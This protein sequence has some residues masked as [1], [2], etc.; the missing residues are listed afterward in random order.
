MKEEGLIDHIC[1]SLHAIPEDIQKIIKTKAFEGIT[2]SYSMLSAANMLPVLDAAYE[3]D[4]G[5]AVMNP[6][7][8]GVIA[9]N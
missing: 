8:G 1:C 5:V 7:G 9:Q 4:I 6:L 3:N 2:I